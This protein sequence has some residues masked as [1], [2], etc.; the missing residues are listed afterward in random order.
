MTILDSLAAYI[1]HVVMPSRVG[2]FMRYTIKA[3]D[4]D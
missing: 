4:N 3:A 2:P 1:A